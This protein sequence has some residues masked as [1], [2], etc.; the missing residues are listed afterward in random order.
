MS[1]VR[2]LGAHCKSA[3]ENYRRTLNSY[4]KTVSELMIGFKAVLESIPS[5]GSRRRRRLHYMVQAALRRNTL[6]R[7]GR[8][9]AGEPVRASDREEE[10][11]VGAGSRGAG[12]RRSR[13]CREALNFITRDISAMEFAGAARRQAGVSHGE[14]WSERGPRCPHARQG[15]LAH[16]ESVGGACARAEE[17]RRICRACLQFRAIA[18]AFGSIEGV[19]RRPLGRRELSSVELGFWHERPVFRPTQ[20]PRDPRDPDRRWGDLRKEP[21][22]RQVRVGF[23]AEKDHPEREHA[24]AE[25]VSAAR[26]S[27][28]SGVFRRRAEA[29]SVEITNRPASRALR[30]GGVRD[31]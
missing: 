23:A 7:N 9:A 26:S 27:S 1:Q 31:T 4:T 24:G 19:L 16:A 12:D 10:E 3:A 30:V 28:R 13:R 8:L 18:P 25:A 5:S 29:K 2:G 11:G 17:H 21:A 22:V 6:V 14:P 15:G 20:R